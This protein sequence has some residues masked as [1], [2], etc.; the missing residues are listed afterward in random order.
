MK[1]TL[2]DGPQVAVIVAES[3]LGKTRLAQAFYEQLA[4]DPEWNPPHA[5]Y[6]PPEFESQDKS[7]SVN[8]YCENHV[9]QGPPKFLWLGMRWQA[10]DRSCRE[11][12]CPLPDMRRLLHSQ[13]TTAGKHYDPWIQAG[14]VLKKELKRSVLDIAAEILPGGGFAKLG[15]EWALA[16]KQDLEGSR[17]SATLYLEKS[18]HDEGNSF[19]KE[20]GDVFTSTA[21]PV[22][23][24]L[25][26]AHWVD[27]ATA[28]FL[29][30][31][32]QEAYK[33][34]WPLL[35]VAT[36]WER[37]WKELK[38]D[39]VG[40][41]SAH[42]SEPPTNL[43]SA[44]AECERPHVI[45]LKKSH[46]ADLQA[47]LSAALPGATPSQHEAIL[48]KSDGN[49]LSLKENVGALLEQ[50]ARFVD[51][52]IRL[53]LNQAGDR[54]IE[55]WKSSRLQ[56]VEQHFTALDTTFQDLLGLSS[57]FGRRFLWGVIDRYA[58][59]HLASGSSSAVEPSGG[60][61]LQQCVDPL[62]IVEKDHQFGEFRDLA[63]CDVAKRYFEDCY[64]K[65]PP[66]LDSILREEVA[67]IVNAGFDVRTDLVHDEGFSSRDTLDC[68]RRLQ[69]MTPSERDEFLTLATRV[70]ALP[71]APDWTRPEDAVSLRTRLLLVDTLV[72][73]RSWVRV[74]ELAEEIARCEPGS[75]PI[76]V[77]RANH[78]ERC[79]WDCSSAGAPKA[80]ARITASL[81]KMERQRASA[82]SLPQA[83]SALAAV[84]LTHGEM[85][86]RSGQLH[87]S[88]LAYQECA[89]LY[90]A[91]NEDPESG[92]TYVPK[93]ENA[94]RCAQEAKWLRGQ[95]TEVEPQFVWKLEVAR[96]AV[97]KAEFPTEYLRDLSIQLE[98]IADDAKN[99]EDW[100]NASAAL[101]EIVLIRDV[102]EQMED[103]QQSRRNLS[104][105]LLDFAEIER[106]RGVPDAADQ[107]YEWSLALQRRLLEEIGESFE[108]KFTSALQIAAEFSLGWGQLGAAEQRFLEALSL[109]RKRAESD[110]IESF[111]KMRETLVSLCEIKQ[112]QGDATAAAHY[113]AQVRDTGL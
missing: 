25:D 50:P 110:D 9:S 53:A 39:E 113:A 79:A 60:D 68:R 65:S 33:R 16:V 59:D 100:E 48:R 22:V 67:A 61:L 63:W 5:R 106:R 66:L 23:L 3:G 73:V 84:L 101:G 85:L 8:P 102:L 24:F 86:H 21:I 34:R 44:L 12:D 62:S 47:Y 105:L 38:K 49:F 69:D 51:R 74:R 31:A 6:W 10:P 104:A 87:Q 58:R 11:Q 2:T 43:V 71:S 37:P 14:R 95:L 78:L 98:D 83:R 7:L 77:A 91:L 99:R 32:L 52:N 26:D 90:A 93:V 72:R 112:Q 13:I 103:T 75:A 36:H 89:E 76:D 108:N 17:V 94:E 70:F 81:L 97:Q 96:R 1:A 111:K 54:L 19:L 20:L 42:P 15:M 29:G 4:T 82:S 80:A 45:F 27:Q 88:E 35:L 46:A 56:R 18:R 92:G 107:A 40:R 41:R 109:L 57:S 28:R 64:S 30:D 55:S